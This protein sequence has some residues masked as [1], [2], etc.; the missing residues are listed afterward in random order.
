MT[1]WSALPFW[2]VDNETSENPAHDNLTNLHWTFNKYDVMHFN[3]Y[4]F[5]GNRNTLT[6]DLNWAKQTVNLLLWNKMLLSK[7]VRAID[8]PYLKGKGGRLMNNKGMQVKNSKQVW[9]NLFSNW[10]RRALTWSHWS[11]TS[12]SSLSSSSLDAPSPSSVLS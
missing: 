3:K 10:K 7:L 5:T 12:A 6:A 8:H 11:T 9:P 2:T 1:M 4:S